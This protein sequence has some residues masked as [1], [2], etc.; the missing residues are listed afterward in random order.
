MFVYLSFMFLRSWC[1][2]CMYV[3]ALCH[4]RSKWCSLAGGNLLLRTHF[5][6]KRLR[7]VPVHSMWGSSCQACFATMTIRPKKPFPLSGAL[8]TVFYQNNRIVTDMAR[9]AAIRLRLASGLGL[10]QHR[11]CTA[12]PNLLCGCW[13]LN[14]GPIKASSLTH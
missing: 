2:A 13:E 4:L 3:Y 11:G 8:V 9:R 6:M 14:S 5:E 7:P 1:F 10:P 12:M